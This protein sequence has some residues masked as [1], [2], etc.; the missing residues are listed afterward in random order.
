MIPGILSLSVQFRS[1]STGLLIGSL[2]R[3]VQAQ[4]SRP[5]WEPDR[6]GPG[7]GPED[8]AAGEEEAAAGPSAA[9]G[10]LLSGECGAVKYSQERGSLQ[11]QI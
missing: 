3:N 2:S 1:P 8:S 11:H 10:F 4:P 7:H 9:S 5:V 6:H